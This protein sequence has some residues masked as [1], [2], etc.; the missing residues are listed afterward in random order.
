MRKIIFD[1]SGCGSVW[2]E[3]LLWEQEAAGSNPVTPIF[4]PVAKLVIAPPCHG[5][6]HGFESRLGR[7]CGCQWSGGLPSWTRG[8]NSHH[9]LLCRYSKNTYSTQTASA[10]GWR[11]KLI[12]KQYCFA[13]IKNIVLF[14]NTCSEKYFSKISGIL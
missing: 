5:G 4:G 9:L 6:G 13:K 10:V 7:F 12:R 11:Q 14:E 3:R 2:L 1:F 8:F